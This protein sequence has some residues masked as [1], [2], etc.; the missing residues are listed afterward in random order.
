MTFMLKWKGRASM[1]MVKRAV[2]LLKCQE[3]CPPWS[4][5][6]LS[7]DS[8]TCAGYGWTPGP[9]E[10]G[11]TICI[12]GLSATVSSWFT[13]FCLILPLS[14]SEQTDCHLMTTLNVILCSGNS[15]WWSLVVVF[16]AIVKIAQC[17]KKFLHWKLSAVNNEFKRKWG[18]QIK[19]LGLHMFISVRFILLTQVA[20]FSFP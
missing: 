6:I 20:L 11:A 1:T 16:T 2:L 18:K 7:L 14:P 10:N 12:H 17:P 9:K 15:S 3:I 4:L 5:K 19:S 8:N 13:S